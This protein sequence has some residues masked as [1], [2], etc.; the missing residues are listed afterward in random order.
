[1]TKKKMLGSHAPNV[2]NKQKKSI[3]CTVVVAV[4][5]LTVKVCNFEQHFFEMLRT[6]ASLGTFGCHDRRFFCKCTEVTDNSYT[7]RAGAILS[8]TGLNQR[9]S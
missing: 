5:C 7:T 4:L 6:V 3:L 2:R 8:Q 9:T 1:M